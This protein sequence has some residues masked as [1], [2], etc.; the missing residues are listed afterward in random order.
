M[1]SYLLL[2]T[3]IIIIIKFLLLTGT[4]KTNRELSA[5]FFFK[6]FIYVFRE[7]RR[8]G[9]REEEKHQCER[10]TL[11]GCLLYAPR[12]GTKPATQACTLTRNRTYDLSLCGTRPPTE[13][14]ESGL[15]NIVLSA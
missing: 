3:N 4:A 13:P 14:H 8:E 2:I 5:K 1:F 10:E 9:E 11:I 12:Q 6:D 7:R 15:P